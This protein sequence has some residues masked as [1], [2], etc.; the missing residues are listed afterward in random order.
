MSAPWCGVIAIVRCRESLLPS[1]TVKRPSMR[2]CATREVSC[3][4][5]DERSRARQHHPVAAHHHT[6][7]S[8]SL[9]IRSRVFRCSSD[10]SRGEQGG[11]PINQSSRWKLTSSLITSTS[12]GVKGRVPRRMTWQMHTHTCC[13]DARCNDYSQH[14]CL[15]CC[16]WQLLSFL[17]LA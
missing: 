14:A 7:C 10:Q 6:E 11:S 12:S 15:C 8:E 9:H 16:C 5:K 1:L 3:G 4:R 13:R 17:A 2:A